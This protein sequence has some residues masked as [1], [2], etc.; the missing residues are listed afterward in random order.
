MS[1]TCV[2]SSWRK[3]D[4]SQTYIRLAAIWKNRNIFSIHNICNVSYRAVCNCLIITKR[5]RIQEARDPQMLKY[6]N[7]L[8]E[9]HRCCWA[10]VLTHL[11]FFPQCF[12]P[13]EGSTPEHPH[14][15][16]L[17]LSQW[18]HSQGS[19]DQ[20]LAFRRYDNGPVSQRKLLRETS[21]HF[22]AGSV[23]GSHSS[24]AGNL[25]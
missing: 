20:V 16:C 10:A 11:P 1:G 15:F 6:P 4:I 25:V 17:Q 5:D 13:M 8:R 12:L 9:G 24:A 7:L 3:L 19:P 21:L 2:I 18:N 14:V 22:L 23:L